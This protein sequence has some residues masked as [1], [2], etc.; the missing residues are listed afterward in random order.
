LAYKAVARQSGLVETQK[1]HKGDNIKNAILL[2]V[3]TLA[4]TQVSCGYNNTQLPAVPDADSGQGVTGGA[5]LDF[6]SVKA[7]FFQP[8]CLRCHSNVGGNKGGINLETY[9]NVSRFLNRA[10]SAVNSGVMPPAGPLPANIKSILNN[11]IVAGAPEFASVNPGA[12]DT[13]NPPVNSNPGNPGD[14]DHDEC[15]NLQFSE[16]T[17]LLKIRN[18]IYFDTNDQSLIQIQRRGGDDCD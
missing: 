17:G 11:W 18:G 7:Q 15:D 6:A 5:G 13:S 8:Q 9:A 4:M 16:A 12:P 14:D 2:S 1:S 10:Q 3:L